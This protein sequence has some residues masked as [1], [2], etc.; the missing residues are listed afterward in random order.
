MVKM[1][2][3][4]LT[5]LKINLIKSNQ[6]GLKSTQHIGCFFVTSLTSFKNSLKIE[7]VI[8]DKTT[9]KEM[10]CQNITIVRIKRGKWVDGKGMGIIFWTLSVPLIFQY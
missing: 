6:F 9:L 1:V 2:Y 5:L 7:K 8:E 3:T 10:K 4:G